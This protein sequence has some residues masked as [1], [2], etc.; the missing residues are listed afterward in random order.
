MRLTAQSIRVRRVRPYSPDEPGA[1]A[2]LGSDSRAEPC[3][4]FSRR[5]AAVFTSLPCAVAHWRT[6]TAFRPPLVSCARCERTAGLDH[7]P[8]GRQDP[9]PPGY[10]A[11]RR[12]PGVRAHLVFGASS[13]DRTVPSASRRWRGH[14]TVRVR[15]HCGVVGHHG[16]MSGG[17]AGGGIKFSRP[18]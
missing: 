1:L 3:R 18:A 8:A 13:P 14:V 12:M 6:S 4:Q 17:G 9:G 15:G 11:M 5:L 2:S 7:Q 10:F 16:G